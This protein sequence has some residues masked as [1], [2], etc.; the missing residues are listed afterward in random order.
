MLD[1]KEITNKDI[2]RRVIYYSFNNK[3]IGVIT[4]F[5]DCYI[6]VRYGGDV[7]SK[8]TYPEDLVF[9]VNV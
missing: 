4:S 8:A 3:E 2:G 9:E 6:F 5:N 7:H 1:I